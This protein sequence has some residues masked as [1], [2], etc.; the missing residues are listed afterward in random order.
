MTDRRLL[1]F[2]GRVAHS[3]LR[4]QVTAERFTDGVPH[5]VIC[6]VAPLRDAPCGRRA[7]ELL[8]GDTFCV[9]EETGGQA[10]GHALRDGYVGYV[11]AAALA[12]EASP[13]TH[14]VSARMTHALG[15]P[16]FKTA[17]AHL[18][19]SL[20]ARLRV[21]CGQGRWGEVA[22]AGFVPNVHL[23]P[24]DE[25]EDDPVAVAER[26]VGTPYVWGGNSALGI[27]CSGLI[28]AGCLACGIACPGDSDMQQAALGQDIPEDVPLRRG[29]LLFWKGHVAWVS[30][31]ATLLHA[32][33]FHMAV[34]H[35]P[36]HDATRRIA[37]QGD[38]P[39]TARKR[40][41]GSIHD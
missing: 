16:D 21:T 1:R 29:D 4:G 17:T 9:L 37:A 41:K 7:R 3:S 27:D 36:L 30:D 6:P 20:G 23:R 28:Q 19:L 14:V 24:V 5:E 2:N 33:V 11:D 40:L 31:A 13:A 22:G 12:L 39:V 32:N 38:G 15:E 10:F 18:P 35:E 26:L 8:Y 34:A 25:P